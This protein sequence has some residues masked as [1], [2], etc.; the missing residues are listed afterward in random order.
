MIRQAEPGDHGSGFKRTADYIMHCKML[1][2]L[3]RLMR[4]IEERYFDWRLN[5]ET[6]LDVERYHPSGEAQYEDAVFYSGLS[7]ARYRR[8]EKRIDLTPEDVVY[9][10]GCGKGASCV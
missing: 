6:T 2:P 3:A 4:S 10:I 1:K 7:Y 9:D 8:M 5:I